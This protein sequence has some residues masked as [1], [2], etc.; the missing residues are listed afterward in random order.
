MDYCIK[1]LFKAFLIGR[2]VSSR[3]TEVFEKKA[4]LRPFFVYGGKKAFKRPF[5]GDR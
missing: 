5:L 2:I 3:N 1:R 4:F